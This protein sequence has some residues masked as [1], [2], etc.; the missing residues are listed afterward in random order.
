[1]KQYKKKQAGK[2]ISP[3][4]KLSNSKSAL[5]MATDGVIV[6]TRIYLYYTVKQTSL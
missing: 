6:V 4:K 1:M 3:Q 2:K 5:D